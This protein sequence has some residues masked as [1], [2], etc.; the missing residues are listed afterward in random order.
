VS[1]SGAGS[2]GGATDAVALTV[3]GPSGALD[4][5]VPAGASAHDVAV[6]YAAQARVDALPTIYTR[7]GDPLAPDASLESAGI[8]AGSLVV[9]LAHSAPR[10]TVTG[11]RRRAEPR[12]SGCPPSSAWP[13]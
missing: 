4:L 9:A 1:G 10:P 13:R 8:G 11:R 7:V 12:P 3:L 5:L 2:A 6:E